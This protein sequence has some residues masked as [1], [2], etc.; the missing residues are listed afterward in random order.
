MNIRNF[1]RI[2]KV[3]TYSIVVFSMVVWSVNA[4]PVDVATAKKV[5]LTQFGLISSA[6]SVTTRSAADLELVYQAGSDEESPYFYVFNSQNQFVM[7]SGDDKAI[8]VLGYSDSGTFDPNNIP[9]N[10]AAFLKGYEEEIAYAIRQITT[11]NSELKQMWADMIEGGGQRVTPVSKNI[12]QGQEEEPVSTRSYSSGDVLI[13]TQWAQSPYYN[14]HC[15]DMGG[16]KAV[17]GCVAT[18]MAQ[19]I[20]YWVVDRGQSLSILG[21]HAYMHSTLGKLSATFG[22]YDFSNMPVKLSS[23][24]TATEVSAVAKLMYH[25][26]VA[27]NMDYNTSASSS[28]LNAN[29]TH[30]LSSYFGF[31]DA[32]YVTRK[33]HSDWGG[34]IKGQIDQGQ[35]VLYNGRGHAW[36]CDGY[37]DA[38]EFHMNWGWGGADCFCALSAI[39]GNGHNFNYDREGAVVD[40]APKDAVAPSGISLAVYKKNGNSSNYLP[41]TNGVTIDVG[42]VLYIYS[43][44]TGPVAKAI[45]WT[46]DNMSIIAIENNWFTSGTDPVSICYLTATAPGTVTIT[47]TVL[48]GASATCD[49]TIN[50]TEVKVTGVSVTPTSVDVTE[51]ETVKLSAEVYPSDAA[52][53]SISWES[54][55]TSVA[56]VESDGTVTGVKAGTAKITVTTDDGNK[57]A[58]C[59][60]MV[61]APVV[62][63]DEVLFD[64]SSLTMIAGGATQTIQATVLPAN[65]NDQSLTWTSSNQKVATVS[66]NGTVTPVGEGT[67]TVRATAKDGSGKYAECSVTVEADKSVKNVSIAPTSVTLNN[68]ESVTL[69]VTVTPSNAI[70]KDVSWSSSN[71]SVAEVSQS[72]VVTAKSK[73]NATI[74]A[75]SDEDPSIKGQCVVSVIQSVTGISLSQIA[76][77][78]ELDDS[79]VTLTATVSPVDANDKT[80]TWTSS[81]TAVATVT[82]GRVT[83]VAPGTSIITATTTDGGFQASC[84]VTVKGLSVI[85]VSDVVIDQPE[86]EEILEGGALQLSFTIQPPNA[87]N[88]SVQWS[89]DN[90]AVAT[91]DANG[92]VTAVGEGTVTITVTTA[93]GGFTA[94]YTL[95]I[96][97]PTGNN[98]PEKASVWSVRGKICMNMPSTTHVYIYDMSG[99][100][101]RR[102]QVTGGYYE[103]SMNRGA[104]IVVTDGGLREKIYVK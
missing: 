53:K 87:T 45:S 79:P 11:R 62:L 18:A 82:N 97:S 85:E 15:P 89:S 43:N 73:G 66:S 63:V 46:A 14:N 94:S 65:A 8:P 59:N 57:T 64:E 19:V 76:I 60:V 83:P 22:G 50:G 28:N 37:N 16:G 27:A 81:N 26:G 55:N 78:M 13:K 90:D 70:N 72:G 71:T 74:T 23:S 3:K 31:A 54:N 93:D 100:L 47:A 42:D 80:M 104:Y 36:I 9:P 84:E 68:G 38:S 88:Q 99:M 67:T 69:S 32:K 49:I 77:E 52:N 25:C 98:L 95:K 4:D 33:D 17:T 21:D 5:A 92:L 51:G 29:A 86:E 103:M 41:S 61:K 35:P 39:I 2:L 102:M 6:G 24:S 56:T 96:A 34:L 10:M 40:I 7:V 75:T 1:F 44:L 48:E 12:R 101:V 20:R 58:E 91:V 30:A